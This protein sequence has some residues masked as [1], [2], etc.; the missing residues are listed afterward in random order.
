V[1]TPF[2][3][4]DLY[5]LAS[6]EQPRL[7]PDA[8]Q[9]AFVRVTVDRGQN[10]YRRAIYLVPTDGS[11]PPRRFSAGT[12][13]DHD[14]RWS[15]DGRSLAFLSK[16]AGG[17]DQLFVMPTN[18]GEAR[19]ITFL[20]QG[21][22]HPAW[23]PDG[24]AIALL[25][26][27]DADERASFLRGQPPS[28]PEDTWERRRAAEQRER[29]EQ[30]RHDPRVIT[31]LPYRSGTNFFDGRRNQIVLVQLPADEDQPATLRLLTDGDLHYSAPIWM[32]NGSALLSTATRD[33][34][35]DSLFAYY[36]LVRVRLPAESDDPAAFPQLERLTGHGHTI[37]DPRPSPDGHWIA[38][39]RAPDDNL[40][41]KGCH[42]A[43]FPVDQPHDVRERD[44]SS[45]TDINVEWLGWT[46][47]SHEILFLGGWRGEALVHSTALDGTAGPLIQG[48]Y[49][50]AEADVGS[51]GSVAFIAG[52]ADNPCDLYI[53]RTDGAVARLSQVNAALLAERAVVPI[54]EIGYLAPDGLE[55]QGWMLRPPGYDPAQRYPL[56]LVIHGGPHVMWGPGFRAMWHEWQTLAAHGYVVFFCNPRGSDGYGERWRDAI[57]A[58]WGRADA[59]DLLAGLEAARQR[60]NIHPDKIVLT[61]G[62]YGGY[63]TTWL[64]AHGDQFCAAV[65][66]RGVYN[67]LT[68][69]GTSDAHEL[70]EFE[71]GGFPWE[72]HEEL[73]AHSPLA[74][75][76]RI[77][78]PLLI[79]HSELDYRVPIS[80]AEQ[81]FSML[82]R[83]K[84]PVEFVRYPREG[85]ELTR[86]GEPHHRADHLRRTIAWFDRF[87]KS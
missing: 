53:R 66:A 26:P 31:R 71:F 48:S 64:I 41:A 74:H 42:V 30:L 32:P 39:R 14:P 76:H 33:P 40:L 69:H 8:R 81:L 15:P 43:V 57:H 56:A 29:D 28:Q 5:R 11:T 12:T 44:L 77:T 60:A 50:I 87:T 59:P 27:L 2:E 54:E 46:P 47:D 72:L 19:Q 16:R 85:H 51:D 23:S 68:E 52:T 70:I 61:G 10:G 80:E 67:L 25:V 35:A 49:L 78:T 6:L 17:P 86:T 79:L 34:E 63:M 82:R 4:D 3:I 84:R 75:A 45:P 7:S 73:W 38:C 24:H 21:V 22:S 37:F 18:G 13:S 36:D 9:V 83:L 65:S 58:N 1:P 20:P 55:V 62:S